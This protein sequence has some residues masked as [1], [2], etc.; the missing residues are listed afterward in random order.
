MFRVMVVAGI[1][2]AMLTP[3][4]AAQPRIV[5][6][7][8]PDGLTLKATLRSASS[9]GPG[10]LLL[11]QCNRQRVIW[12]DLAQRLAAA[13]FHVLAFDLRG[14]G[15]SGGNRFAQSPR[16]EQIKQQALWPADI[17]AALQYLIAQPNV[18]GD[19]VGVAGAS[20]GVNNAVNTARRHPEVPDLAHSFETK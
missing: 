20:C 2:V 18:A 3:T 15:D 14:F 1:L 6:V 7:A 17:D 8:A 13:G 4:A 10:L 16:A 11:H 9:R 5:D 12:N 19:M